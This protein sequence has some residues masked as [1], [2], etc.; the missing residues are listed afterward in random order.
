MF[1]SSRESREVKESIGVQ[2]AGRQWVSK[3]VTFTTS[4]GKFSP[5]L[6]MS[7]V[8]YSSNGRSGGLYTKGILSVG[9]GQKLQN[10]N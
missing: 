3:G 1:I 4:Y 2:W 7:L 5:I 6:G 8:E 9:V 10:N